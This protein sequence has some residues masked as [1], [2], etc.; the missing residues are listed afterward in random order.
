MADETTLL[1]A[2][3]AGHGV[4]HLR[5]AGPWPEA[6]PPLPAEALIAALARHPDPRL[7]EALIPL[8]IRRPEYATHVPGLT[9]SLGQLAAERLRH[10]YTAAVYLQRFWRSTLSIYLGGF[11][12]LP[13]YFGESVFK[14]PEDDGH[15][16]ELNLRRLGEQ[17]E[18]ATRYDWLSV[19]ASAM[20]LALDQMRLEAEHGQFAN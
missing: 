13:D 10:L 3:L 2:Q 5:S 7:N 18:S 1:I 8:F 9:A 19:Y 20:T 15:Y 11:P 14:L 17:L 6:A 4:R 16:G 12:P